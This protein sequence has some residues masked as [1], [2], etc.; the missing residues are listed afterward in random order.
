[1]RLEVQEYMHTSVKLFGLAYG[2]GALTLAERAAIVAF[3]QELEKRFLPS[4]QQEEVP[5]S[6]TSLQHP[7]G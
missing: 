3:A 6:G 5:L 4:H 7:S 2:E 1:M